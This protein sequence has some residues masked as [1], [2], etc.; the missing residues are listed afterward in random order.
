MTEHDDAYLYRL[1]RRS[2]WRGAVPRDTPPPP[3]MPPLTLMLLQPLTQGPDTLDTLIDE[4]GVIPNE[5]AQIGEDH[6]LRALRELVDEGL[7]EVYDIVNE[8]GRPV[9]VLR[10]EPVPAIADLTRFAY[11]NSPAGTERWVA[12]LDE[13]DRWMEAHPGP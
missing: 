11:R 1:L 10:A 9:D 8:G 13:L 2:P 4:D 3:G 6:L 12:G 7:V 5:L